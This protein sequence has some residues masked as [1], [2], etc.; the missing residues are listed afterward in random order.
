MRPVALS[1]QEAVPRVSY[2]VDSYAHEQT[3]RLRM[4]QG[5]GKERNN[6]PYGLLLTLS[7]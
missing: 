3:F 1:V 6:R 2:S 4:L 7:E 5:N